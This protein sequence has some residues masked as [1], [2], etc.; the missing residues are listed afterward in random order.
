MSK[1]PLTPQKSAMLIY[2]YWA[3]AQAVFFLLYLRVTVVVG[4]IFLSLNRD[5]ITYLL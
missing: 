3:T 5:Y 2:I 1:T 4:G